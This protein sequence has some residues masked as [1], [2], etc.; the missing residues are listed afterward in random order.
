MF[1]WISK[2]PA[3]F[4]RPCV[5]RYFEADPTLEGAITDVETALLRRLY[6]SVGV[7][8][9]TQPTDQPNAHPLPP[10]TVDFDADDVPTLREHLRVLRAF[11][12]DKPAGLEERLAARVAAA[13]TRVSL[14]CGDDARVATLLCVLAPYFVGGDRWLV[15]AP[16]AA[17]V[18]TIRYAL[19]GRAEKTAMVMQPSGRRA[20]TILERADVAEALLFTRGL[21][22][23]GAR[24]LIPFVATV[25][26]RSQAQA[27]EQDARYG[28]VVVMSRTILTHSLLARVH[29]DGVIFYGMPY[30]AEIAATYAAPLATIAL[31]DV[32]AA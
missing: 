9:V 11:V 27:A 16:N 28:G 3:F 18:E 23:E 31:T 6:A 19:K 1:G 7:R 22:E 15:I 5:P 20:W 17:A 10:P 8:L 2:Q 4:A 30:D 25:T 24:S 13:P 14:S 12:R 26:R 21:A 29:F 32:G